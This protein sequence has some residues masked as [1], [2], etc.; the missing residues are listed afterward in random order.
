MSEILPNIHSIQSVFD[1]QFLTVFLLVGREG[2]LLVDSGVAD[3]PVKSILPYLD[4]HGLS[5]KKVKWLIV[6]HASGDHFG[7]NHVL[8]DLSPEMTIIAHELDAPSISNHSTFINEHIKTFRDD[9]IP[10]PD[11]NENDTEFIS[12]HG[13]E[14][15][16][17][18]KVR[19][20]EE[21]HLGDGWSV[22]LI[23]TPGHTP[24]HLMVYDS[25]HRALFAGDG[26]MGLGVPDTNGILVMPPSYFELDW[27][28][29]TI[30]KIRQLSPQYL[31]SAHYP[32]FS[33]S[34]ALEFVTES[35]EFLLK[36]NALILAV[37]E[38][39]RM[40]LSISAIIEEVRSEIGIP[41]SDY[42][43]GMSIRAHLRDLANK[44]IVIRQG[45][46]A[47]F[48]WALS[49]LINETADQNFSI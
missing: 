26:I 17:D 14:T 1:S 16:S 6:T 3:T 41:N 15:L 47:P 13:P 19:G 39:S 2:M 49:N 7:G 24:G 44:G 36:M 32:P 38:S 40:P 22:M 30:E 31:L 28:S 25:M 12:I 48:R 5:V 29:D 11:I 33:G 34:K 27:Y 20:G 18:W 43:Y 4:Q 42:Q 9:G 45:R 10:C 46:N 23:H 8:K 21:I 37:L 35:R